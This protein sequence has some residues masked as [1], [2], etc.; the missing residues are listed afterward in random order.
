MSS[1]KRILRDLAPPIAV[2]AIQRLRNRSLRWQGSYADWDAA[3]SATRG[4]AD[5]GI[6]DRVAT[7][8]EQVVRGAACYERDSV[9]FYEPD[10]P[11]PMLTALLQSALQNDRTLRVVDFG[12]SLGSS[13]WQ[14]RPMLESVTLRWC[15]V[16]QP[17]YVALGRAR[18]ANTELS[19]VETLTRDSIGF[20]P[21]VAVASSVL[22][23]LERPDAV[24][25]QIAAVGVRTLIIDRTPIT[26]SEINRICVQHVPD[27]IARSSYPCW[28]FSR[29]RLMER[30]TPKWQVRSEFQ[31]WV[32]SPAQ[33]DDG[34]A[35]TFRGFLL[36]RRP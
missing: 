36:E 6:L 19:F 20:S 28:L 26:N 2:S 35:F 22:Q 21:D 15:V 29:A 8:T 4:Y 16:E 33:T 9:L 18:F 31:S 34:L 10:Y 7:A 23:Y 14:C 1:L 25:E 30:L 11:Y 13:Y 17:H 5:A 3:A 27:R 24:L 32:D 12:G